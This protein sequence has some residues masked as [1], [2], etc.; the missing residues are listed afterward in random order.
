ML[1]EMGCHWT[2]DTM[3][4]CFDRFSLT[5]AHPYIPQVPC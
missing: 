1:N 3:S 4:I 2:D 5:T